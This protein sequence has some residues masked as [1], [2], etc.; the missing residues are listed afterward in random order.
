LLTVFLISLNIWIKGME[1]K[2]GVPQNP[3]VGITALYE[4][5]T[6]YD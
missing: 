4:I 5:T 3:P 6:L 2:N 1:M